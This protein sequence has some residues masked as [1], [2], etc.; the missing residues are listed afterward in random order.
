MRYSLLL[1]SSIIIV[2]ISQPCLAQ[3]DEVYDIP[4][5]A[6]SPD[7][8]SPPW[9]HIAVD[10]SGYVYVT[11]RVNWEIETRKLDSA[12]NSVWTQTIC[13]GLACMPHDIALDANANVYVL[14]T[15]DYVFNDTIMGDC[16]LVLIKYNS[17]GI[18]QWTATYPFN[19]NI[20]YPNVHDN[21]GTAESSAIYGRLE[22]SPEGRSYIWGQRWDRYV[23][24]GWVPHRK[25]GFLL[26]YDNAG[27]EITN[28]MF[29]CPIER[30]GIPGE[31]VS[32]VHTVDLDGNVS[33]AAVTWADL[34]ICPH[35]SPGNTLDTA[36]QYA[37][38]IYE[39]DADG[40]NLY[41]DQHFRNDIVWEPC[42]GGYDGTRSVGINM[43][44]RDICYDG[45]GNKYLFGWAGVVQYGAT[46]QQTFV[47][48][49]DTDWN[50]LWSIPLG[51]WQPSGSMDCD[52][53]GNLVVASMN[54]YSN[55]EVWR[56]DPHGHVMGPSSYIAQTVRMD[57]AGNS[58]AGLHGIRKYDAD[59]NT[60]WSR[61]WGTN[62]VVNEIEVD[63]KGN[64]YAA[65]INWDVVGAVAK[66]EQCATLVVRDAHNDTIP[67]VEFELIKIS[68]DPP[69]YTEDTLGTFT[70]NDLGQLKLRMVRTDSLL[71]ATGPGNDTPD[72]LAIGDT[73]KI[74]KHIH[75]QPAVK[76]PGLLST[77]YSIHLDNGEF[78]PDGLLSFDTLELGVFD[79]VLNHTEIRHNLVASVEWEA[80]FA[81][82][83]ALEE[84]FRYMSNH[85]YDISDGQLRLDTVM[86]YDHR[87]QWDGADM[88]VHATNNI[89]ASAYV[90]GM[91]SAINDWAIY[92]PRKAFFSDV[93]RRNN[94]DIDPLPMV[95]VSGDYR[96]KAHE[97]GH[98]ALSFYDEYMLFDGINYVDDPNLRC[99]AFPLSNYGFMDHQFEQFGEKSSEMSSAYRYEFDPCQNTMQ[100][101]YNH[102]SCWD[103][104]EAAFEDIWGA[105][106]VY[107]PILKPDASDET[108]HH[109]L[110]VS[111][112]F[113]GPNDDISNLDYNV[114]DQISFPVAP[115]P[116]EQDFSN[117][118][119]KIIGTYFPENAAVE[120]VNNPLTVSEQLINQGAPSNA[121]QMWI[122]GVYDPTYWILTSIG[123]VEELFPR[124]LSSSQVRSNW[125]YGLVQSS[126]A[127]D[128]IEIE[129]K[130]VHG[131]YPLIC[132][133]TLLTDSVLFAFAA[134]QMFSE[135]P[136]MTLYPDGQI[137]SSH[138]LTAGTNSYSAS[139]GDSLSYSGSMITWAVDDSSAQFFFPM[140]YRI[141]EPDYSDP[142]IDINGPSN[143]SRYLIDTQN[144]DIE[145][146]M[147]LSSPY[148][149]I[150]TGLDPNA[151]QAGETHCLSVYPTREIQASSIAIRYSDVDL[152]VGDQS[153]GDES[154]LEMYHWGG[155]TQGWQ[156]IGGSVVD[157]AR[158]E[159][160]APFTNTGTYAAFTTNI[161]T[162]VEDDEHGDI[163][164][165]RF[166]L[167]QNYPNPFNPVTTIEYSL[168]QRSSVKIDIF[169]LLGQKVRT[170]VDRE[171]SA[172]SYTIT[173]DGTSTTGEAVSTGVYFYRFQTD[174]H[175][176]TKK[177]LL[178]K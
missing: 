75:S 70:T 46:V 174:D 55:T 18:Y 45:I 40:S 160:W 42:V 123:R 48:K 153:L 43:V 34:E 139:I 81:Y 56:V 115:Q 32:G 101:G 94:T 60:V 157:T 145:K 52:S 109:H 110:T 74:A 7:D 170:L 44:V 11:C 107:A 152:K 27:A 90:G 67:N 41:E 130:E 69:E 19:T 128:S 57:D 142:I 86:I 58:Y 161:I 4:L 171:E 132:E 176:E 76:H 77:A 146:I 63:R 23:V 164:P 165:Y 105:D 25:N 91:Y 147:V 99:L 65:Y 37:I 51:A 149:V 62:I 148:S 95:D 20:H 136:S 72:T 106:N 2:S 85:L 8:V 137:S 6:H 26:I 141:F 111:N 38:W 172:G 16:N 24:D 82:L 39:A 108:E 80:S 168:P 92:M 10:D 169:N 175:V 54:G 12:G 102:S 116:Q 53:A 28:S 117:V 13:E 5:S 3:L 124:A 104:L 129:M 61:W 113:P 96:T 84:N 35:I 156:A 126:G 135:V 79:V 125:Q 59:L 120:L 83:D 33:I 138:D 127:V 49:F 17:N 122:L 158:N 131:Y 9:P 1:L 151:V 78:D 159:V 50:Q 119:I 154:T 14:G 166:E 140:D 73:L 103:Q 29:V 112:I 64:M 177:M 88:R 22:V 134:E 163:L 89:R 118:H 133:A 150:R 21:V 162:D 31:N 155:V 15:T 36:Y 121:G 144:E 114:G 93:D 66:F 87:E 167:S 47:T 97:F 173:W 98:Y 178:L 71:F 68:N 143:Q 30:N 100:W